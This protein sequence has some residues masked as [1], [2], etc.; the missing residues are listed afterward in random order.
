MFT[1][2]DASISRAS[3][4]RPSRLYQQF[5]QGVC[6]AGASM[7]TNMSCGNPTRADRHPGSFRINM[8]TG[9]W[10]EFAI[11]AGGGDP[12]S[13]VAYLE[14]VRQPK[15]ARLLGRMLSID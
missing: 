13:L 3:T 5:S 9:K 12:V 8:R 15:A 6:P 1:T 10:A 14:N 7:L 11:G 4:Q 2:F